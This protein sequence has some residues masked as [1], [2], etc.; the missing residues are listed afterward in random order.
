[1]HSGEV[2]PPCGE[3]GGEGDVKPAEVIRFDEL[4]WPQVAELS[5]D[6]PL[7]IPVG[8]GGYDL[9]AAARRLH[10]AQVVVLPAVPYG[11]PR[12]DGDRL[13]AV[14]V[15]KGLLRR[16]LSG[17]QR[18]LTA[19]GFERVYFV[20]GH[21]LAGWAG[22]R[23]LRARLRAGEAL[24]W[25]ED[26]PDRVVVVSIGH[27]EQHGH[28][29]PTGTDTFIA[30]ALADGLAA[31]LPGEVVCLPV[32]PYGVSTHTRQFPATLN[33]GGRT[34]EDFYLAV[35]SR[36]VAVG[37]RMIY[38]SNAHGGNH[39]FLVNVVKL[40]GERWPHV[41]TATEWLH[42]TGP[43]LAS[44]RESGRGGMGHG[45]ELETSYLLHLRPDLV[46]MRRATVETEFIS[47]PNYYMDWIEAGRLIAN[48]PWSDDTESGVYGD[49]R[50][51][52]PEKGR[53]WLEAAVAERVESVREVRE[54]HHRRQAKRALASGRY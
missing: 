23:F 36:L 9:A 3:I 6:T 7:L 15:G 12:R 30:A 49:G 33:L 34:F 32:W 50:L 52:A 4:T 20:D 5:R 37:A 40:A 21:G 45:G 44:I 18:E 28:H 10:A 43:A 31:A 46:D 25:P 38:F 11:F 54:Q 14:A 16:A 1:M 27:T 48:P 17:I 26:L 22:L 41:F 24:P 29:L 51:G 47:T 2:V 42:T 39:S 8:L 35:T 19:Q 13:A 53:R